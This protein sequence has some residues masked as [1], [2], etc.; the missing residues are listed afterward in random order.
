MPK[1]EIDFSKNVI[2]KIQHKTN[3]K[4]LYIGQT[5]DFY[6]RKYQHKMNCKTRKTLLYST[7]CDNGGWDSFEMTKIKEYPCDNKRQA[8]DEETRLIKDLNATLNTRQNENTFVLN[9]N[10]TNEGYNKLNK[11]VRQCLCC[12]SLRE[13][14]SFLNKHQKELR[15]CGTCRLKRLKKKNEPLILNQVETNNIEPVVSI[16]E[17]KVET[18]TDM[19]YYL[20]LHNRK[21]SK[22]N[23]EFVERASFPRHKYE[24][25]HVMVDIRDCLT[26][27]Y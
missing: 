27:N 22:F 23:R 2:Y 18:E 8:E 19:T 1:C 20:L 6:K 4:L 21:W 24:M 5:T 14:T 11:Q 10:E 16:T 17:K 12:N 7:I 15:T 26:Y 3:E 25:R 13:K 9:N